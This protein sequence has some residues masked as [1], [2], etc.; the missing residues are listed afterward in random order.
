MDQLV[1]NSA[2]ILARVRFV[3]ISWEQ[4]Y[5]HFASF[6]YRLIEHVVETNQWTNFDGFFDRLEGIG[7][8]IYVQPPGPDLKANMNEIE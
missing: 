8:N 3:P 7:L 4:T 5:V 1:N 2:L 6:Y